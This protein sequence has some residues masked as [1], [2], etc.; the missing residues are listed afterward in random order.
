MTKKR[1]LKARY[2]LLTCFSGG[3]NEFVREDKKNVYVDLGTEGF[4]TS[5]SENPKR[6]PLIEWIVKVDN[7]NNNNNNNFI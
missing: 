1:Q 3:T 2:C 6:S 5:K 4:K 7:N